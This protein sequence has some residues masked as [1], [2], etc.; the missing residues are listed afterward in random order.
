MLERGQT[1]MNVRCADCDHVWA[2]VYL[3]APLGDVAEVILNG[4]CPKCGSRSNRHY[5]APDHPL[6]VAR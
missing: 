6:E 4:R 2:P 5:L 1:P 3:P